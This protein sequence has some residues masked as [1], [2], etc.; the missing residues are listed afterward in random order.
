[1]F[2]MMLKPIDEPCLYLGTGNY[3]MRNG[4]E[5]GGVGHQGLV[6]V[7]LKRPLILDPRRTKRLIEKYRT[8]KGDPSKIQDGAQKLSDDV[9]EMGHD[10]II[11][12]AGTA[13]RRQMTVVTLDDA[14]EASLPSAK[15]HRLHFAA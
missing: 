3:F 8:R 2:A 1:M 11:A 14:S 4:N 10:G 6:R 12:I 7:E 15:L 5:V 9:R 13:K